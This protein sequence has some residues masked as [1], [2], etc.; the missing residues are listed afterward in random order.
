[1][2]YSS[3]KREGG[4]LGA[5]AGSAAGAWAAAG[6]EV[7][8]AGLEVASERRLRSGRRRLEKGARLRG[9]VSMSPY[10]QCPVR[11]LALGLYRGL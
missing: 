1:M 10:G 11:S 4:R 8:A 2:F 3:F 5:A 7:A 9:W 6:S